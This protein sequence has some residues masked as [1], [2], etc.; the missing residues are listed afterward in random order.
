[1]NE[2]LQT[3]DQAL[4]GALQ[5]SGCVT[6]ESV[7]RWRDAAARDA[8]RLP[9]AETYYIPRNSPIPDAVL[10]RLPSFNGGSP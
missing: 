7:A 9:G 6:E 3:N 5:A 1:M 8:I 2:G 10:R 4:V